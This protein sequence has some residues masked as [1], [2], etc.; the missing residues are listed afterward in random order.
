M[1]RALL[2]LIL[3]AIATSVY[4]CH[5]GRDALGASEAYSAL[6]A[7]QP[8][9]REVAESALAND[10][11]K[12]IFYHLLL[13][14]FT[15]AFG[16]SEASLRS[17]SVLFGVASLGLLLTYGSEL[18]GCGVGLCAGALWAFSPIAVVFA[19]WARMY[20]MFVAFALAHLLVLGRLRHG[21]SAALWVVGGILGAAM[22]YTHF[23]GA[24]IV[25]AD[26]VVVVREYRRDGRSATWPA[27]ALAVALYLPFVPIEIRQTRALLFG[28]WLDWIG[29][30]HGSPATS[31]AC[32]GLAVALGLWLMLGRR[33]IPERAESFHRC[34]IYALLPPVALLAGSVVI[35]PMFSARYAGP[36]IAMMAL[37]AAYL[38]DLAGA[39]V[40]NLAT[41]GAAAFLLMLT[42][43]EYAG[44]RQPWRSIAGEIAACAHPDE[45]IVFESG[46]FTPQ[47]RLGEELTG[48][49]HG[50]ANGF[51]RVP[52]DYYFHLHNPG[53]AIPGGDS[54]RSRMLLA[55]WAE[56][57]GGVWLISGKDWP[58]AIAELPRDHRLVIDR[59]GSFARIFVFHIRS[60][61]AAESPEGQICAQSRPLRTGKVP[62]PAQPVGVKSW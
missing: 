60:R 45:P 3:L 33:R 36:S 19:R 2:L 13:H 48:P 39:R 57:D 10:P 16:N 9:I 26:V 14:W 15:R 29:V 35:R 27:V 61:A 55:A 11:G 6:A 38:L 42:P 44:L 18:F 50:F 8:N 22:L 47:E 1:L 7:S 41:V 12:P 23:G 51:F 24:L 31:A 28:H 46:F 4:S 25:G 17:L 34:L 52:F 58:G 62:P 43:L 56:K 54:A 30:G 40:R 21:A 5:L 37:V 59:V 32:A 53:L 20:A 49:D